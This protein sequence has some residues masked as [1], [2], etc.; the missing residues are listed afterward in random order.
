MNDIPERSNFFSS[1]YTDLDRRQVAE[2]F[3]SLGWEVR[4]CSWSDYKMRCSF[5][6]LVVEARSPI[7]MHGAVADVVANL[8]RIL[9]PLR[10]AGI[11]YSGEC[12]DEGAKLLG[13]YNS[14]TDASNLPPT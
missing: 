5:A 8:D 9:S 2:L 3:R 11:C 12:Y 13:E 6:E 1:L 10:E 14:G 7:L 4:K